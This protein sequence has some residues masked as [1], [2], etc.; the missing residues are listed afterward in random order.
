MNASVGRSV[1]VRGWGTALPT[2]TV[3]NTDLEAF[4]DTSD[5]WITTRTGIRSRQIATE[6]ETTLPLAVQATR[7]ALEHADITAQGVDLVLLATS[8][9]E[10]PL[11]PTASELT[12]ALDT[13]AGAFDVAA[14]CAG[15][16]YVLTIADAM[17]RARVADRVLAVGADTM[18]RIIDP[19]DRSTA[20][21]FG[22]GAGAVVLEGASPSPGRPRAG[23]V[24]SDLC[25]DGGGV[26]LLGIRAGGAREPATADTVAAGGHYL[27]MRGQPLFQRVVR[28][29]TASVKRTLERAGCSPAEVAWFVP[30]QANTRI[31]DAIANRV[32]L[33]SDR[34]GINVDR[35]GNTSSASIPLLL[36]ELADADRF[37]DGDLVLVS[38]FGAGLSVST[39]LWRWG[40]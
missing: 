21:L 22:D 14:A 38:G 39:V 3:T 12:A 17:I 28:A 26:D 35:V 36:A 11:P 32:G 7:R 18:S 2:T 16:A 15:F 6:G 30:H 37:A 10:H 33:R 13:P 29:V 1:T 5:E 34:V 20:V 19:H 23:L 24:A 31:C 25:S 27:T 40:R 8:T 9:P 4:L